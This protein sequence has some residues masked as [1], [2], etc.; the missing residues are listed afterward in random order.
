MLFLPIALWSAF[1]PLGA[2][3]S[4]DHLK[5]SLAERREAT[6][7]E[8]NLPRA[9]VRSQPS[10]ARLAF[11]GLLVN[12]ACIYFFNYAHKRGLTWKDGS[13][14]HWVLWQNRIATTWAGWLRLRPPQRLRRP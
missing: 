5:R 6:P 9:M 1:L 13:A 14:V 4:I 3:F 2:R 12:F 7:S 10:Y 11:F 8:L